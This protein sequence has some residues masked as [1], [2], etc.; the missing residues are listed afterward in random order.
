M[1]CIGK[2]TLPCRRQ[3]FDKV[4][5]LCRFVG[6][7]D[8]PTCRGGPAG[9][10]AAKR[11]RA[12]EPDPGASKAAAGDLEVRH[13]RIER[14]Y[15]SHTDI[16]GDDPRPGLEPI[17][18]EASSALRRL[19]A[20]GA[21]ET[22]S[23]EA[24]ESFLSRLASFRRRWAEIRELFLDEHRAFRTAKGVR[25]SRERLVED[26]KGVQRAAAEKQWSDRMD[27]ALTIAE[28]RGAALE[29]AEPTW[30]PKEATDLRAIWNDLRASAESEIARADAAVKARPAAVAGTVDAGI[31]NGAEEPDPAEAIFSAFDEEVAREEPTEDLRGEAAASSSS[32][33]LPP[34]GTAPPPARRPEKEPPRSRA[35]AP[36]ADEVAEEEDDSP[37]SGVEEASPPR[38]SWAPILW[39]AAG[40]AAAT[41]LFGLLGRRG[42]F[43]ARG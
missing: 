18:A 8:C 24:I 12:P 3:V 29:A 35:P 11:A 43:R 5:P 14:L 16:F 23:A 33:V 42:R 37:A 17:R 10:P 30:L 38:R 40:F 36:P 19:K 34:P 39:S 27:I 26:A 22:P 9:P 28:Q 32:S 6:K 31:E 41:F 4:C 21:A 7:V 13:E 25:G 20:A 15:L 2:G 1:T